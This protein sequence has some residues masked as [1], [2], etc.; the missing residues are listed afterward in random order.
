MRIFY[1]AD[2]TPN[3]AFA[4]SL[5]RD[6]LYR[7]LVDL[8]H[9]VTEFDY[10]LSEVY[11]NLDPSDAAQKRYIDRTRPRT[12]AELLRQIER[13]HARERV[14]LFFSYFYDACV[15]PETI[16]AVRAM[17]IKT[18]NWFCNGAHQIHLV[19]RIAPRYD[20]CLVP[21]SFRLADYAALGARPIHCQEAANPEIYK[22]YDLPVEFDATF[23]GQAYGERPAAVRFLRDAG[24]DVRVW[25][26]GWSALAGI[27]SGTRRGWAGRLRSAPGMMM[28]P[29]GRR[30]VA[31]AVRRR[32][33]PPAGDATP[34]ATLPA[35]IVGPPL[36]DQE[37]I[38]M[39]SRSR[40]NLGFS[41]CG[42]PDLLKERI[43]QVRLRDFEVPMS[44]GFYLVEY[45]PELEE[46]FAVGKEIACYS[47]LHDLADK[48]KY[49]LAHETE[50][51][52]VRLAGLRRARRD[53]TWQGRFQRVLEQVGLQPA[54]SSCS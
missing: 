52:D 17:G 46:Y 37:M 23:V 49:Y 1:A 21:E 20:W 41:A 15:T 40:I 12:S 18:M 34:A 2:S 42:D 38:R 26:Q 29:E 5:W 14:D 39:Y 48:I 28:T 30:A 13:A 54:R 51:Q 31:R 50:R 4:S 3:S 47:D 10:D 19:S 32:L 9:D 44:G 11:R 16:D 45:M 53:H 27:A 36:P 25:G 6:N 7:P 8:G 43:L 33:A 22:P 35:S 24:I